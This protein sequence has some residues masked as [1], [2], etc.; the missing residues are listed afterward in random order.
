MV[1]VSV[2]RLINCKVKKP[3]VT[4]LYGLKDF[5]Q[6]YNPIT[7]NDGNCEIEKTIVEFTNSVS[8]FT[9]EYPFDCLTVDEIVKNSALY[10]LTR[11]DLWKTR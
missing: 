8:S 7:L 1:S 4:G 6:N 10:F 11:G 2:T 3:K 9:I 5:D